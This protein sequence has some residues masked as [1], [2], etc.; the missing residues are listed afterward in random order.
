MTSAILKVVQ[1]IAN[2]ILRLAQTIADENG[3][4]NSALRNDIQTK[5]RDLANPV[6]EVYFNDY[7]DYI[8]N[9][10]APNG[11]MPPVAALRDWA[12]QNNISADNSTLWAIARSIKINGQKPRPILALLEQ[13]IDQSF[14]NE[15]SDM[16]LES[17]TNEIEQLFGNR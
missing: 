5:V 11:K 10:R 7:V 13:Q 9:G 12:L 1:V 4:R 15:W 14:E 2:D 16:I 17:I 3:L 6:I 8:E